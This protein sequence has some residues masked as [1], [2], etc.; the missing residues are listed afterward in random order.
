MSYE[1][2]FDYYEGPLD[3]LLNLVEEKKLE[4]TAVN[5]AEVT[6]DFIK[7]VETLEAE[8][9]RGTIADFLIVAS[10]LI[11]IKSKVLLPGLE[12]SE[13]EESDVRSLE[14]RLKLYKELK[15]AQ[16]RIKS[17]WSV[18]PLMA[19]R[20]FLA[21]ISSLF[22]PPSKVSP[23]VLLAA[24]E[25]VAGEFEK[26]MK[27]VGIVR[28]EV[29]HLKHKIQEILERISGTPFSFGSMHKGKARG[30]I[31]VLF[32]AILH[33]VKDQII[34]VA[35]ENHFGDIEVVARAKKNH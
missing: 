12:L 16:A 29:I 10:K 13:E 3:K 25:G 27:P 28:Q 33:L 4:I 17:G 18:P 8:G 11:L 6:A 23:S 35:Q 20:E 24:I 30:E 19:E 34:D 22:F 15:L 26:I 32:L 14:F 7:Y 2:K 5:L 31:V 1:L 9:A 21:S